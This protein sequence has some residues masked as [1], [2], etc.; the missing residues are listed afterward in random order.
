MQFA[1]VA[2]ALKTQNCYTSNLNYLFSIILKT[3]KNTSPFLQNFPCCAKKL[4]TPGLLHRS[5]G[6]WN[7]KKC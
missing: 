6:V 1:D 7:T 4:K 3:R 5:P 2:K